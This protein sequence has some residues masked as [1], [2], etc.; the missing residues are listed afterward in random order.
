MAFSLPV[1]VT[2]GTDPRR[3]EKVLL[4]AAR[5]AIREGVPGLLA[6]PE[7]SVSF[8]PG[9]GSSSLDFSLSLQISQFT[10]QFPIQSDIRKRI[11]GKF[12]EA[13]IEM[14]L[15]ARTRATDRPQELPV[16]LRN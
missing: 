10:D 11:V 15:P 1:S 16:A 4:E 12:Q 9:F 8:I 14:P 13:G 6:E 5:D 3:V 7:P 2:Y